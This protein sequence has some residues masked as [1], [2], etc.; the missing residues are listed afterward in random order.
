MSFIWK[1]SCYIYIALWM[2]YYLQQMLMIRGVISQGLLTAILLMSFYSFFQVNANFK[3]G[4]YL[5]WLN[6]MLLVLSVYGAVPLVGGWTM[7]GEYS[8]WSSVSYTYLQR[9]YCSLLPIYSFYYYTLTRR[10]SSSN[11]LYIYIAFLLYTILLYY[12]RYYFYI[13]MGMEDFTNNMGFYFVPLIPMLYIIRIGDFWKYLFLLVSFSFILLSVK[14]GAIL[15]GGVLVVLFLAQYLKDSSGKRFAYLLSLSVIAVVI[16]GYYVTNLYVNDEYFHRRAVATMSGNMSGREYLYNAS[17][18]HF[19]EKTTVLEFLIGNGANSTW[20]LFG[21]YAH[22]DWLEFAINQGVIGV[23]MY[24]VY[25]VTF[26][27]EWKCYKGGHDCRF[28]LGSIIVALFLQT[29]HSMTIDIIP[30]VTALCLGYCLAMSIKAQSLENLR[31]KDM[32]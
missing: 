24:I 1:Y 15:G 25:W 21:N 5:K 22:N 3:T 20:F 31:K 11:L 17:I 29:F 9:I 10:I 18:S 13:D 4:P 6:I 32:Q 12:Q 27:W 16:I 7:T 2:I 30:T 8:N 28:V 14:R 26:I 23:L 19:L